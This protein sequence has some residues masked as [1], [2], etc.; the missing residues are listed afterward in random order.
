MRKWMALYLAGVL[1]LGLAACGGPGQSQSVPSDPPEVSDPAEE[2]TQLPEETPTAPAASEAGSLDSPPELEVSTLYRSDVITA[3]C[4][5]FSWRHEM[6]DG[7]GG[8]VIACG[9]SPLDQGWEKPLLYT[10]FGPGTLPPLEEGEYRS[11]ILP[12]YYLDFGAVPPDTLTARRWSVD[13]I[14][15]TADFD[16]AEEVSVEWIE[17]WDAKGRVPYGLEE[18]VDMAWGCYAL[19]PLGDGEFVYEVNAKWDDWGNAQYVFQ[20]LPQVR[21]EG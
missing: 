19:Y 1:C 5:N 7:T 2:T 9:A 10:A 14:G 6:P 16:N 20:T 3:A 4:G 8:E 21:G 13:S 11:T 17:V 12:V 18:W 15:Q